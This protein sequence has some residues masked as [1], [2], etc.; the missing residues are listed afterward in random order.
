MSEDSGT[1]ACTRIGTVVSPRTDADDTTGW[2]GVVAVI[3]VEEGLGADSLLGL[4]DYSHVEVLV[5]FDRV[6]PRESYA[7]PT[8][9]RG[10]ARYPR[11][12]VFAGR[13]PNRPNP[14]GV[15]VCRLLS[16]DGRWVTVVGLDAVDGTPVIDLKPVLPALLPSGPVTEPAWSRALMHDYWV[17]DNPHQPATTHD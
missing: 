17:R 11:V 2:G 4:A 1:M 6:R 15:T 14:I 12:G 9:P 8:H 5:W 13:G 3:E 10:D 7:E 16:V